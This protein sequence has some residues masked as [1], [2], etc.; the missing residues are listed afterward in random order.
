MEPQTIQGEVSHH[1]YPLTFN[2]SSNQYTRERE[3]P[4]KTNLLNMFYAEHLE[5]GGATRIPVGIP[6][7]KAYG[8]QCW[9][10]VK[11]MNCAYR[12]SVPSTHIR[13]PLTPAPG[14]LAPSAVLLGYSHTQN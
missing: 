2:V 4:S 13:R 5:V 7:F 11:S 6:D 9:L 14:A 3:I 12:G 1:V 10:S 8:L